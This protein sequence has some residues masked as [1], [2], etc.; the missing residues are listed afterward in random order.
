L[1]GDF[2]VG[3]TIE[4]ATADYIKRITGKTLIIEVDGKE[5]ES[6]IVE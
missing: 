2:G 1:S 4:E 5:Y 6:D 3:N